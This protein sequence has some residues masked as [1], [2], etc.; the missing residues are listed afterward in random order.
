MS[1]K[2]KLNKVAIWEGAIGLGYTICSGMD[3]L[4]YHENF[5][6]SLQNPFTATKYFLYALS[7]LAFIEVY[8]PKRKK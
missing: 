2:D 8:G 6:K 3:S 7:A 5:I 4:Y 1:L